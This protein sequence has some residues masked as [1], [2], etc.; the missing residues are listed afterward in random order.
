MKS[1]I[2]KTIGR[3]LDKLN[4]V[5]AEYK[6]QSIVYSFAEFGKGSH[7]GYPFNIAGKNVY[8]HFENPEDAKN[9]HIGEGVSLGKG[10]AMYATRAKIFIGDK[11]FTG[12]NVTIMTGDHPYDIK[13][14]YIADNMK[15]KLSAEGHDISVYDK[16][17]RIDED[18]WIGCNVTILKGVHIG[19]GSIIAAGSVVT[20]S[21][22]AYSIAG[23][24]N[25]KVA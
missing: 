5:Y 11:T 20:Q 13:G 17:V 15:N 3:V 22:P 2:I 10:I 14:A 21:F 4:Q 25:F 6:S 23:G 12:P 18:V 7:V 9:I 16:D 24:G 19:R 8:E 1:F